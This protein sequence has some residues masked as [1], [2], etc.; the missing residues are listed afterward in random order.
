[1]RRQSSAVRTPLKARRKQ[2]RKR[3][4][5]ILATALLVLF[6][7]AEFVLWQP[8]LRVETVTATGPDSEQVQAFVKDRL[9]GARFFLVPRSSIFFIPEEE[10]RTDI[11]AAFPEV[12]AVTLSPSGLTTL[13]IEGTGRASV[14]WWC[15]TAIDMPFGSCYQTDSQGLVFAEVPLEQRY[16]TDS[17]LS[18]YAPLAESGETVGNTVLHAAALPQLIQ[19][20]KAMRA[21]NANVVSVAIRSD[22][23]DLYTSAG[24]RITYVLGR[25]TQAAA[26][27]ASGFPTLNLNDGSLEYVDLRFDA[28]IFFKKKGQ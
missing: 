8:W 1:M 25:E 13:S 16:A 14:M 24:T 3:I 21:L 19:F 10:I 12:A 6:A 28:K 4:L 26:L 5:I 9:S 23:A 18:L 20:V 11:L 17:V 27:A 2:A 15:G 22:E 7:I